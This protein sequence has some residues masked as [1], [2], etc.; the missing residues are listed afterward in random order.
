MRR[1]GGGGGT[2]VQESVAEDLEEVGFGGAHRHLPP[3]QPSRRQPC[4]VRDLWPHPPP[5]H[6]TPSLDHRLACA[7]VA[8]ACKMPADPV[9]AA[10]GIL[11]VDRG[12]ANL[13][14]WMILEHVAAALQVRDL[15]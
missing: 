11:P 4:K 7:S 9:R 13:P 3:V 14:A 6:R 12:A 5:F 15:T 1:G 10:M 2:G 8:S